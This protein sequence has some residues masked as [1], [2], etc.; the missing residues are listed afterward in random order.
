M[1]SKVFNEILRQRRPKERLSSGTFLLE[2]IG[3][4]FL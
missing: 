1:I 2:A 4:E 3:V